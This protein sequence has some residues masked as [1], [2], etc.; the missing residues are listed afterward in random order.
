[1]LTF[2]IRKIPSKAVKCKKCI[3]YSPNGTCNLFKYNVGMENPWA[4]AE[5][6]TTSAVFCR[7]SYGHCGPTGKYFKQGD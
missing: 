1:M 4:F 2:Y 5:E 6:K 7:I 3:H